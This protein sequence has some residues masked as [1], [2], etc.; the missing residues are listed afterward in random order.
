MIVYK[1]GGASVKSAQGIINL[2]KI[3]RECKDD[4]VVVI[5][6]FGKTTNALEK[7][8]VFY[9]QQN[10]AR[11]KLLNELKEYHLGIS[12]ELFPKGKNDFFSDLKEIFN[13]FETK[14]QVNPTTAFDFEY[15]QMVSLGELLSTMI[16]S[17]YLNHSGIINQWID[18]RKVLITDTNFRE[19]NIDWDESGARMKE[20]LSFTDQKVFLTQGF[21][22]GSMDGYTTTLGRE[23]SDYTAAIIGN[24][25]DA[26]S[27]TVWKDVPGIMTADPEFY[28][29]VEKI[30]ELSF[31]EAIELA[32][33]GA[34]V[35]H[36][37]TVKP[38]QN[39]E[40]PLFVKSFLN[41]Q[42]SGTI[43]KTKVENKSKKPVIILK[44]NQILISLVP[45]DFSFVIEESL[46]KIFGYFFKYQIRVNL[47]QN[48]AINFSLCV[49][50]GNSKIA[51]L[52]EE[53]QN[54]FKILYN[55]NVSLLTILHYSNEVIGKTLKDYK[56][57]LEQRSR[58]N[59]R[60]VVK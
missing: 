41:P 34:K 10:P 26:E 6:A 11:F 55:E 54:D 51:V 42:Q 58:N 5:S 18:I 60:F 16:V 36:P 15:D 47:I 50:Y 27:V 40:I 33:F 12:K 9:Y 46:S 8:L 3:V 19:A 24:I 2:A 28:Q 39:K 30:D 14:L 56:V 44:S 38:L 35:I 13:Q 1:F 22:G 37:K 29:D 48:S 32:Y 21:I 49:D 25:M 53:L 7:I 59:V 20:I 17:A 23:G 31:Q 57:L 4:L 52:M 45:K 43:I